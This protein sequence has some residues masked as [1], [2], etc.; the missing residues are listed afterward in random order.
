MNDFA[1][2]FISYY[3][4]NSLELIIIGFMLFIGSIVVVSM[5]SI[6][7]LSKRLS[8]NLITS[9]L[10]SYTKLYETLFLR[11]QSLN[12]QSY[13]SDSLKHVL[14]KLRDYKDDIES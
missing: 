12:Y 9:F 1:G 6:I 2:L 3:I 10:S 7:N 4:T 5:Y 14:P 13:R 8:I 11:L